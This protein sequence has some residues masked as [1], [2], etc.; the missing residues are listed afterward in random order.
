MSRRSL[1]GVLIGLGAA[2]CP[3]V[4]FAQMMGMDE[5]MHEI[6]PTKDP[7]YILSYKTSTF[8]FIAG[9]YV[10]DDGYVL[11]PVGET[12]KYISLDSTTIQQLQQEGTLPTPLP[13]YSLSIW[14]YLIGYSNWI[15]LAV[16][17]GVVV[18]RMVLKSRTPTPQPSLPQRPRAEPQAAGAAEAAT[19]SDKE[20]CYLCGKRL[21]ADE[22][23][24]RVCQACRT[25][26][27]EKGA[28]TP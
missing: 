1:A 8:F 15:I 12:N 14:D 22:L 25:S 26:Q 13:T 6:Q 16:I 28:E 2:L 3:S 27:P 24:S 21:E 7:Q 20:L 18:L 23:A 4:G 10:K 19:A 17:V 9:C 11:Q 5:H